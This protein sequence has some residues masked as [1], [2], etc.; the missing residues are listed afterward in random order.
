VTASW[1][2]AAQRALDAAPEPVTFFVRDD[3]IGW[4]DERLFAVVDLFGE[5]ELPI[6]LAVI[7]LALTRAVADRLRL[8]DVHQHG[9]A[10]VNHEPTGRKCEFGPAR[11]RM[12]QLLDIVE[13]SQRLRDLLPSARPIFTPPWNRCTRETAECVRELG[14][15]VLS[16]D[17][18]AGS[19]DLPGLVELPITFD[20]FAKGLT[21]AERGDLLARQIS[22]ARPVGIMLHHALMDA[23]ELAALREL[24]LMLATHPRARAT[25]MA[26]Q[27]QLGD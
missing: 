24:L 4:A 21:R 26:A 14:F 3:D 9:C 12:E 27:A 7:P 11:T 5:L 6:D 22:S 16:R 20:W 25:T 13:G 8:F 15:A 18:S 1:L 23:E 2:V 10:H 17:V 19:V